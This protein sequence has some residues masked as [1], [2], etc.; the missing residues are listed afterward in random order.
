MPQPHRLETGDRSENAN[1]CTASDTSAMTLIRFKADNKT[2]KSYVWQIDI[3]RSIRPPVCLHAMFE[4]C[5]ETTEN[6]KKSI[7]TWKSVHSLQAHAFFIVMFYVL[8]YT[9]GVT[10]ITKMV[11]ITM[12]TKHVLPT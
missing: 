4:D 7:S 9:R 12:T 6:V 5:D 3:V 10:K 8:T 11:I 2:L 1:A